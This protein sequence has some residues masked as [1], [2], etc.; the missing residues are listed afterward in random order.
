MA[1][2]WRVLCMSIVGIVI[3]REGSCQP[4]N[5]EQ[6]IEDDSS[7][8]ESLLRD[9][10]KLV[11]PSKPL[12]LHYGVSPV[13]IVDVDSKR[14]LL[15]VDLWLKNRWN[16]PRLSWDI[17]VYG[18]GPVHY[19]PKHI[20]VPEVELY[21][22]MA[23]AVIHEPNVVV[24]P[25]G[26]VVYF[27][28]VRAEIYCD[29]PEA[30]FEDMICPI[31]IGPWSHDVRQTTLAPFEPV[32]DRSFVDNS[33]SCIIG[34][35]TAYIDSISYDCCPGLA[36]D[37]ILL[38]L[39]V[40]CSHHE[41]RHIRAASPSQALK[42]NPLEVDTPEKQPRCFVPLIITPFF[43]L[44]VFLLPRKATDRIF[45]GTI[46]FVALLLIW[47]SGDVPVDVQRF[48]QLSSGMIIAATLTSLVSCKLIGG[49]PT[50]LAKSAED[51][52]NAYGCKS[53]LGAMIDL[54]LF[55]SVAIVLGISA[56][57]TFA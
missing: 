34:T 37:A 9:Y 6:E 35:S 2:T 23:T 46:V 14:G 44:L 38:Y 17:D 16:D 10:N 20:Y 55:A 15:T 49:H 22:G 54:M 19:R 31:K 30:P 41:E 12:T 32:V 29:L 7:L 11:A 48:I 39:N 33:G 50:S 42:M 53:R 1:L 57:G 40:S 13:N 26:A 25:S 28:T 56:A 24:Y 47:T 45:F 5:N 52:P 43:V 36:F 27:P 8:F 51:E 4:L 18:S 3:C 21:N